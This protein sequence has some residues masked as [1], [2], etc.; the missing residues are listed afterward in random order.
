MQALL[1]FEQ[2]INSEQG[3]DFTANWN[4]LQSSMHFNQLKFQID[5][6]TAYKEYVHYHEKEYKDTLAIAK[7]TESLA[8]VGSKADKMMT[9]VISQYRDWSVSKSNR[10][11]GYAQCLLV[12]EGRTTIKELRDKTR[13]II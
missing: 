7:L 11:I 3:C 6:E 5:Q 4:L 13:E 10:W 8:T 9:S 2:W 1:T 12:A